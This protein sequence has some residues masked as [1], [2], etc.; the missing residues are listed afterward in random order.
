MNRQVVLE[1]IKYGIDK[2]LFLLMYAMS[3][4]NKELKILKSQF[5]NIFTVIF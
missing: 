4:L 3:L 5:H 2:H 1:V